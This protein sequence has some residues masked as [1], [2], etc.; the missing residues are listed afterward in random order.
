[1]AE[2]PINID[3]TPPVVAGID[4]TPNP[5]TSKTAELGLTTRVN[6]KSTVIIKL[7]NTTN[8]ATTAYLT[9]AT[10]APDGGSYIAS[11]SWKYGDMFAKGPEDGLYNIE[12]IAR[13]A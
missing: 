2:A 3:S 8:N 11:Y 10:K 7:N 12:I 4:V 6:E 5:M 1:M 13:D 9:Q